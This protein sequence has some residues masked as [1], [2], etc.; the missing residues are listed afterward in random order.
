[1]PSSLQGRLTL[2]VHSTDSFAECWHPFFKLLECYW[3][4]CP[5]PVFLSTEVF[6]F[7]SEAFEIVC[8]KVGEKLARENPRSWTERLQIAL[9]RIDTPYVLY[10][11]EDYFLNAPVRHDVIEKLVDLM[12]REDYTHVRL[13][14]LGGN[15]GYKPSIE[16]E[17]L[18]EL[19]QRG[20]YRISLQAGIWNR[21]RFLSYLKPGETP[22]DIERQGS[23]RAF[24]RKDT[25]FCVNRNKFNKDG[26]WI[27]P[28]EPTGI[29]KGKWYEPAVVNLFALHGIS[30]DFSRR[31]FFRPTATQRLGQ[32]MRSRLRALI[33]RF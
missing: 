4:C 8:T 32:S 10:V 23:R 30:V 27:F 22:W 25:F 31:G 6:E 20:G 14:E 16:Y 29:V 21:E 5:R 24:K 1:M 33:M 15:A 18:W 26:H 17:D 2:L 3:P 19:P 13:T 28:Y 7:A 9:Q 12:Q 11:Q